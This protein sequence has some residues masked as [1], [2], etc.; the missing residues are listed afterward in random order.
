MSQDR[1]A[2]SER[3]WAL[4]ELDRRLRSRAPITPAA[5][6]STSTPSTPPPVTRENLTFVP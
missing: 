6:A 4:G 5:S 1:R 3:V 2:E